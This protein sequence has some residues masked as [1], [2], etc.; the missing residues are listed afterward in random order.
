[1]HRRPF[2]LA[3]VALAGLPLAGCGGGPP[4]PTILALTVKAAADANRDGTGAAK[5]LRVRVLRLGASQTFL[6][7]DFFALDAD[8]QRALGKDLLAFDDLV[9]PADGAIVFERELEPD[10]RFLGVMGA[11][12]AID[13]TQWR[14]VRPVQ[15]SVTNVMTASFAADG[16]TLEGPGA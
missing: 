14:A 11:Y 4:P 3:A 9:V 5:P 6:Q 1:M 2:L 7:A 10:A 8:P 12:F 16:V 13:R 15:R